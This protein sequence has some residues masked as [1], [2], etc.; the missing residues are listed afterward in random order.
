MCINSL[1]LNDEEPT[2]C[3][4]FLRLP[5]CERAF[6]DFAANSLECLSEIDNDSIFQYFSFKFNTIYFIT[7]MTATY[8]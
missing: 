1:E 4:F 2:N 5:H 6:W 7:I 8:F 3:I